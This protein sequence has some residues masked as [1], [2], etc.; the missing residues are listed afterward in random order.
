[1]NTADRTQAESGA[2]V[3]GPLVRISG[4]DFTW[5][6][7]QAFRLQ[8]DDFIV[9]R[10]RKVLL[11]GPSGSGKSTLLSLIC[12]INIPNAGRVEIAGTDLARLG[13]AARD[14][15]RAEHIAIMFQQFNLLPFGS[16]L[17]NILLPLHFAPQRKRR[18]QAHGPLQDEATRLLSAL[19]LGA[20]IVHRPAAS[21]SVGQQQRVA[22]ARSL[23]GA[24]ELILADEP[25]S[26]LDRGRQEQFLELLFAEADRA[27][28]TVLMVSHDE[29]LRPMFDRVVPLLGITCGPLADEAAADRE[30]IA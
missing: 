25:T 30:A 3:E 12:G 5:S 21:L 7:T 2:P 20:D 24:P 18:V 14:R 16:V 1:M 17:D 26:A 23:I 10:G 11:T 13:S 22:A 27:N 8:I 9:E 19:G 4:V 29:S 28:A 6:E 15:F